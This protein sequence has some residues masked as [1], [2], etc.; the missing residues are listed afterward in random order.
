VQFPAQIWPDRSV[1]T[2]ARVL[3][4]ITRNWN[5]ATGRTRTAVMKFG[6]QV[7]AALVANSEI[8]GLNGSAG[9]NLQVA[10][11]AAWS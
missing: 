4:F 7:E 9:S 8:T 2:N 5:G 6:L 10:Y 3:G 11:D 1:Q